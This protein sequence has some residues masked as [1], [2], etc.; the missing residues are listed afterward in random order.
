MKDYLGNEI[1]LGDEV[2]LVK[3]SYR[4]FVIGIVTKITD[5]TAFIDYMH[6]GHK[7]D[8]KQSPEQIIVKRKIQ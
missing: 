4:E 5:K 7:R 1:N 8:C 2:I 6:Q 3:P